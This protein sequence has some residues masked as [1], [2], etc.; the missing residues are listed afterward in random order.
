MLYH[1]ELVISDAFRTKLVDLKRQKDELGEEVEWN[2]AMALLRKQLKNQD[3]RYLAESVFTVRREDQSALIEWTLFFMSMIKYCAA[4]TIVMPVKLYY[5]LFIGQVSVLEIKHVIYAYPRTEDECDAFVFD[6]YRDHVKTLQ[7]DKM[8]TFYAKQVRSFTATMLVAQKSVRF[9]DKND[10]EPPDPDGKDSSASKKTER[11]CKS[12]KCKH[13][14]GKHTDDG[15]KRYKQQQAANKLKKEKADGKQETQHE[16]NATESGGGQRR[17]NRNTRTPGRCYQCGERHFPFCERVPGKRGPCHVCKKTHFPYCPRPKKET[18]S[19]DQ[20]K[21]TLELKITEILEK[22]INELFMMTAIVAGAMSDICRATISIVA[23]DGK[24][25]E[26][27]ASPDSVSSI[28]I[29]KKKYLH[30]VKAEDSGPI[31]GFAGVD[32]LDEAGYLLIPHPTKPGVAVIKAGVDKGNLPSNV[33][34][35]LSKEHCA[36]LA[37]DVNVLCRKPQTG[38]VPALTYDERTVKGFCATHFVVGKDSQEHDCKVAEGIKLSGKYATGYRSI[39]YPNGSIVLVKTDQLKK[40]PDF[41]L[42]ASPQ[43]EYTH[44]TVLVTVAGMLLLT[45]E[46]LDTF[47][48]PGGKIEGDETSEQCAERELS[49][50]TGFD[51]KGAKLTLIGDY[52]EG[53]NRCAVFS[54]A[55]DGKPHKIEIRRTATAKDYANG[56]QSGQFFPILSFIDSVDQ[57]KRGAKGAIA[58]RFDTLGNTRRMHLLQSMRAHTETT[59]F[60][61][62]SEMEPELLTDE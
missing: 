58:T 53:P 49:E 32:S 12:C 26:V 55:L 62:G 16:T 11:Y 13:A 23:P 18:H 38:E 5:Q 30:G 40:K 61:E 7:Q 22:R 6:D 10:E 43:I 9:D 1:I 20:G 45:K 52:V 47:W 25:T 15:R 60:A 27:V 51:L 59:F 33:D 19:T 3:T 24:K 2:D 41:R 8:P 46:K 29:S 35:L 37:A 31:G 44:A 14:K 36:M 48:T 56:I 4:A 39:S 21:D 28:S 42:G 54:I 57:R 34:I 50:E 17:S